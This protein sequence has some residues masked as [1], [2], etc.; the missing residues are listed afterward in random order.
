MLGGVLNN[1]AQL[2]TDEKD[3]DAYLVLGDPTEGALISAAANLGLMQTELTGVFPRVVRFLL[4]PSE[5][6]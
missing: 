5:S 3:P 1:N 4:V 2:V 6:G